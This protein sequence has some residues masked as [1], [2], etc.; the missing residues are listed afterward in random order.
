[1]KKKPVAKKTATKKTAAPAKAKPG[2]LA[3]LIAAVRN[4]IQSAR[5]GVASV[6]D[7]F[8]VMTNFEIGRRIV[9]H[10]HK[11]AK[12]AA[13]GKEMLIELSFRLTDEFGR[14]FSVSNLQFMRLFFLQFSVRIQQT[15]SVKLAATQKHQTLSGELAPAGKPQ[16]PF[17]ELASVQIFQTPTEKL[18]ATGKRQTSSGELALAAKGQQPADQLEISGQPIRKSPFTLSWSHYVLLLTIKDPDER[19]F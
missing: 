16:T 14:G 1:V 2:D 7:T 12:R 3:P 11:G 6:V 17:A 13:Y 9:E 8:Q 4:L 5:R 19:S 10:E 15:P 18:L